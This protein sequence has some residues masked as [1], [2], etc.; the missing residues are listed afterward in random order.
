MESS[1]KGQLGG[2]KDFVARRVGTAAASKLDD[3]GVAG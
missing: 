3:T 1:Q 2:Q